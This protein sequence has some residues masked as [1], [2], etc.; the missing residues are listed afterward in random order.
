MPPTRSSPVLLKGVG[1]QLATPPIPGALRYE[2]VFHDP[3]TDRPI[4]TGVDCLAAI[5]PAGEGMSVDRT[6]LFHFPGGSLDAN[7]ITTAAPVTGG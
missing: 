7:G 2:T 4:G 3:K 6:T 1:I 5:T